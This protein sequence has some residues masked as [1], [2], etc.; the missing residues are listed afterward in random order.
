MSYMRW[1][2]ANGV[3][4]CGTGLGW[5]VVMMGEAFPRAPPIV[6][7]AL[8]VSGRGRALSDAFFL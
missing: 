4:H 3:S 6:L 2:A 1:A 7:I 5:A 8:G